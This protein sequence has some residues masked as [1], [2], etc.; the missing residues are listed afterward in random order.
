VGE[1][2]WDDA[3]TGQT[4]PNFY[5]GYN[6]VEGRRH[7]RLRVVVYRIVAGWAVPGE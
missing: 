7:P 3:I 4:V 6:P 1:V 5:A 2:R